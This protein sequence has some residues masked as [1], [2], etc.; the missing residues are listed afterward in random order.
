MGSLEENVPRKG[1]TYFFKEVFMCVCI[2]GR[3]DKRPDK[4]GKGLGRAVFRE[5][6]VPALHINIRDP[7]LEMDR[8]K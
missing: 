4:R 5:L 7:M 3:P 1:K 6:R 2:F 8:S